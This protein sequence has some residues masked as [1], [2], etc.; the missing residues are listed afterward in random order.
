ML[1]LRNHEVLPQDS[2]TV[3]NDL[4]LCHGAPLMILAAL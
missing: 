3:T 1:A 4:P 2:Q